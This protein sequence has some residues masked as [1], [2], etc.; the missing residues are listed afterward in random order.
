MA[1]NNN[2]QEEQNTIEVLDENLSNMGRRVET[3]KK[4]IYVAFG[5]IIL[6]AAL[7]FGYIYLIRNPKVE[8]AYD[9]YNQV[10][11]TAMNNDSVSAAEYKKVADQ[12]SSTDAGK[13][14]AL[15]AAEAFYN[16]GDYK[17]AAAMLEKFSTKDK[18]L[19]ANATTLLGDCYVNLKNYDK[20]IETF[21]KAIKECDGNPQI[22]PRVL[23]KEAVVFDAQKK[24]DKALEC[25]ESIKKNYPEFTLGGGVTLD[26][27]IEREK[28][29]LG[30]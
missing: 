24:Y 14:A 22:A 25:Y 26:S 10:E 18:V 13:L 9:A 30:K 16:T 21:N 6:I 11:I 12:Y 2:Q 28:A 23:L 5:G 17:Q 7:T 8:K 1:T 3:N 19:G 20:A 27:Y 4:A 29:R 15:S